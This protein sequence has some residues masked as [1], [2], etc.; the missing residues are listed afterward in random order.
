MENIPSDETIKEILEEDHA[1]IKNGGKKKS[2]LVRALILII[3]LIVIFFS[4]V[5]VQQYLLDL[6]AE[7]IVRAAQTTTTLANEPLTKNSPVS[8]EAQP[9]ILNSVEQPTPTPDLETERTAT[10]STQLTSVAEFQKTVT[11]EP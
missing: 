4:F 10:V 8:D 9:D 7:A 11:S 6:E 1:E 2:C 5:Y 3:L